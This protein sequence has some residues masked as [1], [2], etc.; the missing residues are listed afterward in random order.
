M[1]RDDDPRP[2][3]LLDL[4]RRAVK[5]RPGFSLEDVEVRAVD[6]DERVVAEPERQ[7][8]A[9]PEGHHL[10]VARP[11]PVGRA[12]RRLGMALGLDG[13]GLPLLIRDDLVGE[14]G[15]SEREGDRVA[16]T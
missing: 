9:A 6:V 11:L 14:G 15:L 2:R 7:L 5:L 8:A 13:P 10:A 3:V 1:S 16:S 4:L 12:E